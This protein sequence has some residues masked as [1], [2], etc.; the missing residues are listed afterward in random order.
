MQAQVHE[1]TRAVQAELQTLLQAHSDQV[2]SQLQLHYSVMGSHVLGQPPLLPKDRP[3]TTTTA[4]TTTTMQN[5]SWEPERVPRP[6]PPE[7]QVDFS[8]LPVPPL[9]PLPIPSIRDK[10]RSVRQ[11]I[12]EHQHVSEGLPAPPPRTNRLLP[13]ISD[14]Q[15]VENVVPCHQTRLLPHIHDV[16][17][18]LRQQQ[19][20]MPAPSPSWNE[21]SFVI[22]ELDRVLGHNR[23]LNIPIVPP[24]PA[25]SP[26]GP[27]KCTYVVNESDRLL[28]QRHPPGGD[29]KIE[30]TTTSVSPSSVGL[31]DLGRGLSGHFH[32]EVDM[33]G[34]RHGWQQQQQ[35]QEGPIHGAVL[36][37]PRVLRTLNPNPTT[38][39]SSDPDADPNS[40]QP[41]SSDTVDGEETQD[42]GQ[43][44]GASSEKASSN[45]SV[46]EVQVRPPVVDNLPR[47]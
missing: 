10:E 22:S 5:G 41:A 20:A 12:G 21:T 24:S 19:Q 16:D 39:T 8:K 9:Q 13:H 35:Q 43:D 45:H 38:E 2:Y 36:A 29:V 46:R 7:I 28:R 33:T 1:S 25:P 3:T 4:T 34:L 11:K 47:V 14:V 18:I 6:S 15:K 31:N 40:T 23:P 27:T 44:M 30:K 42:S 32:K 37:L 17:R 26:G